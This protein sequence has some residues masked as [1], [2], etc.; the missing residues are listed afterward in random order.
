MQ[1]GTAH[2]YDMNMIDRFAHENEYFIEMGMIN[3]K[4]GLKHTGQ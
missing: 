3:D 2:E 1:S 4:D